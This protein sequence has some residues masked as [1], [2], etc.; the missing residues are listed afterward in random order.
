MIQLAENS[1]SPK[2]LRR[3]LGKTAYSRVHGD[4]VNYLL[5]EAVRLD[6]P[7]SPSSPRQLGWIADHLTKRNER[8]ER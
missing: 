2:S 7:I 3:Q 8:K 4:D 6:Y 1:L 5:S